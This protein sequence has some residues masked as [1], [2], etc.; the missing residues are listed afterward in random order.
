MKRKLSDQTQRNIQSERK[1][2]ELEGDMSEGFGQ[3][4]ENMNY[5]LGE[6]IKAI[7]NYQQQY[8]NQGA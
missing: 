6:V 8:S 5:H 7:N 3:L 4:R 1:I 2:I